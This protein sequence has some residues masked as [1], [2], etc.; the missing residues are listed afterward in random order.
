M[1]YHMVE[2]LGMLVVVVVLVVVGVVVE[3]LLLVVDRV[4]VGVVVLVLVIYLLQVV[5]F[6]SEHTILVNF[7]TVFKTGLG[8]GQ[9]CLH[10]FT[11]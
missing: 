8:L 11:M 4:L 1:Y 2:D 9:R 3:V 10:L 7:V 5:M 6:L